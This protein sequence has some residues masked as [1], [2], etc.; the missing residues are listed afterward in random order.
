MNVFT[1]RRR[2]VITVGSLAA[3]TALGVTVTVLPATAD[4][5]ARDTG[6]HGLTHGDG[7]AT[8]HGSGTSSGAGTT[9]GTATATGTSTVLAASL[10]G[11]NEVP[12]ASGAAVGDPDGGALLFLRV[13]GDKVSVAVKWHGVTPPT[14][15]HIHDGVKGVNGAIEVDYTPLLGAARGNS[16]T[17]TVTVTDRTVLQR[18]RDDPAGF[19]ANLHTAEFPGG[20]VRGQLHKV[21]ARVDFPNA[22]D[23]F[24]ASVVKGE[25]IYRCERNRAGGHSFAQRDVRAVLDGRIGHTFTRPGSGIPRWVARDGSAVTGEVVGRTPNGAAN[26]P[27]LDLRAKK[28]GKKQGLLATTAEILRLNTTGGVAPVGNCEPGTVKG[29]PYGADY[30][31][32]QR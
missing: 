4:S 17:A 23:N 14:A 7:H 1:N 28:S 9:E 30:V 12:P 2:T 26:I 13:K 29:V 27:E 18:L 8:G 31:F 20:A 25:Q 3:A 19:Y 21:T 5:G 6:G 10:R 32:V 11:A 22:L 24:Q 15:L 16:L